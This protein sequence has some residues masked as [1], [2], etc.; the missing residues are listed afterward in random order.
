MLL[1]AVDVLHFNENVA[2]ITDVTL[3]EDDTSVAF[4]YKGSEVQPHAQHEAS[5]WLDPGPYPP[6][7]EV[8]RTRCNQ[9]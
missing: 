7:R 3:A 4:P 8:L 6:S 9:S 2:F 1:K 5:I